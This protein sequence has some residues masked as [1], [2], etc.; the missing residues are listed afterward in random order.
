MYHDT[1]LSPM[2]FEID[3]APAM[4]QLLTTTEREWIQVA[5]LIHDSIEDKVGIVKA[6]YD[7]GIL[8]IRT[9]PLE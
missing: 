3:D 2:E 8:C 4:E 7:E 5:D 1:P 6:L 9:E